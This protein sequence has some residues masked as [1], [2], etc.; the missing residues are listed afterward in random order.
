MSSSV[1]FP[2]PFGPIMNRSSPHRIEKF[3]PSSALKPSKLT[4][5]S[6]TSSMFA[7]AVIDLDSFRCA[8]R[9]GGDGICGCWDHSFVGTATEPGNHFIPCADDAAGKEQDGTDKERPQKILPD[10]RKRFAKGRFP[11][12]DQHCAEN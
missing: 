2:A 12:V 3:K 8:S 11:P 10:V 9:F 4:V 5:T 6:W 1:V 7:S